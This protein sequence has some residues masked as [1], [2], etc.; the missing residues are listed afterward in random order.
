MG[1]TACCTAAR[2]RTGSAAKA[3]SHGENHPYLGL[4]RNERK[5]VIQCLIVISRRRRP[6]P[7]LLPPACAPNAPAGYQQVSSD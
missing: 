3:L 6:R 1:G 2:Q 4:I 7:G 5:E